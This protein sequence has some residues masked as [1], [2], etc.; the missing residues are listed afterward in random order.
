[1]DKLAINSHVKTGKTGER[2]RSS[3][4]NQGVTAG[5]GRGTFV[6]I[7]R[8]RATDGLMKALQKQQQQPR[9][10]TVSVCYHTGAQWEREVS[11][12]SKI[13][14]RSENIMTIGGGEKRHQYYWVTSWK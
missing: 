8:L 3:I 4:P 6:L 2:G 10:W 5:K 9:L 13:K 12:L 1:M 14:T 11:P 7:G